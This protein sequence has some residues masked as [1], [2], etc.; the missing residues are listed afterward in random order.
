M[1]SLTQNEARMME[2]LLRNFSQDYSIN[3]LARELQLSPGGAHKILKKLEGRDFLESEEVGNSIVYKINFSSEDALDACKF[4]LSGRE[5]GPYLEAWI[6]DLER[7]KPQTKLAVLFGSVLEKGKEAR[8][9]DV[10]L[11]FP[12]ERVEEIEQAIEKLNRIKSK[13]VHPIYQTKEDLVK[14]IK[15]RDE[16]ILE[17]I[18][19]GVILWGRGQ[20]VEAIRDGES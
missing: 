4:V 1:V 16:A 5:V 9:V 15:R 7:L 10:L 20:L 3:Q 19:T 18:R 6:K 17:E 13:R 11:V 14:N 8:D 12:E 2:F